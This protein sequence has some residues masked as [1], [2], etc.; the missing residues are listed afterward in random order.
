MKQIKAMNLK[1]KYKLYFMK[2]YGEKIS[3]TIIRNN[4]KI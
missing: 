1:E 3:T 4:A 2:Y